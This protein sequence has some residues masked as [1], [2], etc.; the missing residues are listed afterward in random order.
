MG[1]PADPPGSV[2]GVPSYDLTHPQ[3]V[4]DHAIH[5]PG[6]PDVMLGKFDTPNPAD[7]YI[8]QAEAKG[9]T[10]FSSAEWNAIKKAQGLDDQGMFDL[11]N[12]WFLEEQ[13]YAGKTFH[14]ASDPRGDFGYLGQEL[15]WLRYRGY[16][17]DPE[18]MTAIP[19]WLE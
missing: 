4:L 8:N 17:L 16:V 3:E 7:N 13:I 10:Y 14:F 12:K 18:T 19:R 11:Y 2:P 9:Y 15:Q 1:P 6:S 5:N